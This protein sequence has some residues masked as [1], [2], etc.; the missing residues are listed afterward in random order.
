MLST[1]R[2]WM[3]S[4]RKGYCGPREAAVL[5]LDGSVVPVPDLTDWSGSHKILSSLRP[6]EVEATFCKAPKGGWGGT[7]EVMGLRGPH[8]IYVSSMG[9]DLDACV[10]EML[11][12]LIDFAT[13]SHGLEQDPAAKLDALLASHDWYSAY[14]DAPGVSAAGDHDWD[15]IRKLMAAMDPTVVRPLFDKHAP[16]G[17]S[18][19]V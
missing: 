7:A 6:D 1:L 2:R 4:N 12:K 10:A 3:N 13:K 17:M 19:P 16:E 18:C 15:N 14:S 8:S 5:M 11:R 9:D